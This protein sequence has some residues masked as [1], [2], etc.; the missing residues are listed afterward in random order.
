MPAS[1]NIVKNTTES[2]YVVL[3]PVP[4]GEAGCAAARHK[5]AMEEKY[6]TDT[7]VETCVI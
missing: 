2:K 1:R 4:V 3:S 6:A 5:S 7:P